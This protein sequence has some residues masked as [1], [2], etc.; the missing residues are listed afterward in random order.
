MNSTNLKHESVAFANKSKSPVPFCQK[1]FPQFLRNDVFRVCMFTLNCKGK[2]LVIDAPIVMGIINTTPDSFYVGSR[3]N[4]VDEVLFRAESMIREGVTILDVGGQSTRP[5][6][7]VVSREEEL[8]RAIPAIEAIHKNF[9]QQIISVDTFYS[10]VAKEAIAGGAAI[11]N[12]VSAGALDPNLL[13]TV[14]SMQVPYVLMHMPGDPQTMQQKAQYKNVT[15]EVFDF[16]NFK[17]AELVKLGVHDIIV[18]AGFGFGKTS[19]H[20]FQLLR[21]L[22][23]FKQL[24][25]PLMVGLSRKATIY[26]TL[27]IAAEEALN[28]TTVMHTLALL[29]G[30]NMLRV[31]DVKEAVEAVK[32]F[33]EYKK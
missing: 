17:I 11:V 10:N 20:N 25:R 3:A 14:A 24:D 16:L 29:N 8:R 12:D 7:E 30:A 32:L 1:I 33:Q 21:E 23:Y 2:L 22:S 19:S 5:K 31:H 18:D 26:K 15:L 6:S 27:G 28:G 13:S 4:L 9:P